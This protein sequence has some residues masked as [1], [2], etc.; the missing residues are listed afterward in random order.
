M[1]GMYQTT[2]G[3]HNHRSHRDDGY[4]LPAGVRVATDWLRDAGYFTANLRELP[5]RVRLQRHAARP[6]G[7]SPTKAS[8]S[9]RTAGTTSS[10]INPSSR[11][12]ISRKRTAR[13]VSPKQADPAKVVIPPYYPDHPVTRE[14][15]AQ[16]LDAATELDAK[17]GR[18]LRQLETDGLA[19]TTPSSC[20]PAIT[21]R[22]TCAA[23]S[24]ATTAACTSR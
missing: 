24:S 15:W 3:A 11:K 6:T 10:R 1:T 5:Q 2:I 16:Y 4:Q 13:S 21:A 12:S 7:I 23:N 22:R 17:V 8:R 19:D 20:S 14:D 9:I 18:I